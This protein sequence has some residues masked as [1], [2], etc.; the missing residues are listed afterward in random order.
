M[1]QTKVVSPPRLFRSILCPIDFSDHSATA[2]RYAAAIAKRTAAR[3]HALYVN[4]PLLVAAA[5]VAL[6]DRDNVTAALRELRTFVASAVP[7]RATGGEIDC[8][9]ETGDAAKL[10]ASTAQ[11][12]KCDLVAMGTH[13]LSGI[14]KALIGSTTERMLRRTS[15]PVLA[16]PPTPPDA[17]GAS[18]PSR[19]WPGPAIMAPVDLRDRSLRDVKDAEKI[20]RAFG[21]KLVLVHVVPRFQPPP[22]YRTDLSAHGRVRVAKAQRDVE[23]LAKAVGRGVTTESRVL[24][25][26][27]PDEIAA[28]AAEKRIG[29][30]VM[31][32]R[33]GPGF[34]GSRAG[35]IAS[36]VLRHA[37]TPVLALPDHAK[38]SL[39]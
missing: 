39:G 27:P 22:W 16:V 28:L 6:N 29:L 1:P 4:D 17:S 36:H 9:V 34:F 14:E 19:S 37:V 23:S 24:A 25:G 8:I 35:S 5:A 7:A 31:H 12:L 3:L 26:S 38:G 13:G 20:A 33:K 2:L 15:L 30:V 21:A 32:L 18:A 11:R 10:I